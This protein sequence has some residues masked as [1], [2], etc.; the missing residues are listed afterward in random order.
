MYTQEQLLK[1]LSQDHCGFEHITDAVNAISGH[2]VE[3]QQG[4]FESQALQIVDDHLHEAYDEVVKLGTNF[5]VPSV[6]LQDNITM[7]LPMLDKGEFSILQEWVTNEDDFRYNEKPKEPEGHSINGVPIK[8]MSEKT[9]EKHFYAAS[10]LIDDILD[11][12]VSRSGKER[13]KNHP[14]FKEV[15]EMT[16]KQLANF[17][18]EVVLKHADNPEDLGLILLNGLTKTETE[19]R[20]IKPVETKPK[21]EKPVSEGLKVTHF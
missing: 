3:E 8:E 7:P 16:D 5:G 15:R 4:T 17:R 2:L 20:Q 12:K 1:A 9:L 13:D 10:S 14:I 19:K 18:R 21:K 11:E 6:T